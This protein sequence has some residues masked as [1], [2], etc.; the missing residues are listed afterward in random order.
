MTKKIEDPRQID[1]ED[2]LMLDEFATPAPD[3][4]T[5]TLHRLLES[6]PGLTQKEQDFIRLHEKMHETYAA[7]RKKPK[8][9]N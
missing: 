4:I 6:N 9:L 2:W 7:L 8:R 1:L 3:K 5:A